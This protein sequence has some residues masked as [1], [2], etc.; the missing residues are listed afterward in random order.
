MIQTEI[1][2]RMNLKLK[3]WGKTL[4]A[5]IL[6]KI[7][8]FAVCTLAEQNSAPQFFF[9][10]NDAPLCIVF[11][12]LLHREKGG[13]M[14]LQMPFKKEQKVLETTNAL[15]A[16]LQICSY[17]IVFLNKKVYILVYFFELLTTCYFE[18]PITKSLIGCQARKYRE[19]KC[20][21]LLIGMQF[22]LQ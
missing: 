12:S 8:V 17:E 10:G 20:C 5:H 4:S 16:K 15:L 13:K 18:F 3:D 2:S 19:N 6:N 22:L 21:T 11:F 14:A 1:R 7:R 9:F